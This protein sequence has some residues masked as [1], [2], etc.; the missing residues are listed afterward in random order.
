MLVTELVRKHC[1]FIQKL[2]QLNAPRTDEPAEP[3]TQ[4]YLPFL[5][6]RSSIFQNRIDRE[7]LQI[8]EK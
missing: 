8:K 3:Q 5:S 2:I 6:V 7:K 4:F 1:K